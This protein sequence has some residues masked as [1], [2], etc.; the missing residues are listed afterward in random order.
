MESLPD[1]KLSVGFFGAMEKRFLGPCFK[2]CWLN[3]Q[4]L[5]FEKAGEI[6]NSLNNNLPVKSMVLIL[7]R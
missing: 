2:I 7:N 4:V 3:K 1:E 6:V 5:P